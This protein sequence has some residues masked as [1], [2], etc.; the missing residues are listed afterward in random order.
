MKDSAEKKLNVIRIDEELIR[1][2][3]SLAKL[4]LNDSEVARFTTDFKDI[5]NAFRVIDEVDVKG[6]KSSFR[7]VEQKNFTRKDETKKCLTQEE[8]L[9]FTKNKERGF[10]LGPGTIE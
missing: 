3:A 1:K 4:E 9:K 6:V 5:L 10:F 7:P 2:V 8:A